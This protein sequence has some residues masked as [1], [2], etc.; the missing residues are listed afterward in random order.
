MVA[1]SQLF[2][3]QA[4]IVGVIGA[5]F[6]NGFVTGANL[7]YSLAHVLFLTEPRSYVIVIP[8]VTMFRGF[9][10]SFGASL[11]GGLFTRTLKASLVDGFAG[12]DMLEGRE[13]LIRQLLGTPKLV[14]ELQGEE[15]IVAIQGYEDGLKMLFLAGAGLAF[16]MAFVQAGTGWRGP[17]EKHGLENIAARAEQS[18]VSSVDN[19]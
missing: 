12:R 15:R 6:A 14:G 18:E 11:S 8:L 3:A 10:A 19:T 1:V 2:T 9:S 4:S 5:L 16:M 7:N 17:K 13:E